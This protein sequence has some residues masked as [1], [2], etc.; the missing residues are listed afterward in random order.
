MQ[1]MPVRARQRTPLSAAGLI[2]LCFATALGLALILGQAPT[3]AHA[4]GGA[5]N[6][7]YV[8]GGGADR[9]QLVVVDVARRQ[10]TGHVELGSD[11]RAVVLSLDGRYAYVPRAGRNDVAV[12]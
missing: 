10:V 3:T 12:V 11:P 1:S 6:L 2:V 9:A 8:V 7:A 4:D 5:P